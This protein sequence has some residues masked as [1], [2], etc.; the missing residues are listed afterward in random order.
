MLSVQDQAILNKISGRDIDVAMAHNNL[1]S[2]CHLLYPNFYTEE[3]EYLRDLCDKVEHFIEHSDK[4]FLIINAPPRHGKSLTAQCSTAWIFGR[5][6]KHR[7]M[8]ASYN[9]DVASVFSRSVRDTISTEPMGE[10]IVY[11]TIFPKSK[12]KYGDAAA[13]SWKLEGNNQYAYLA[14]SPNGTATGFGC[15]FLICDDLIKNA[16]EAYNDAALEKTWSWFTNTM[17]SRLEGMRKTIVIMTRW[18]TGD[19]AGRIMNSYGDDLEVIT[20]RAQSKEGKMLCPEI[21]DAKSYDLIK[22][23]MNPDIAEANYNQTPI[24]IKGRLYEELKVWKEKPEM[25]I[26]RAM[27]DTA[28]KGDDFYVSVVYGVYEHEAY[29][30][31]V[32]CSDK[33][34]EYTE[35]A[36]VTQFTEY[37]VNKADF[38]S[39]NGGRGI[40]R[41]VERLLRESGNYKTQII[42]HDQ[43]HN[44]ESRILASSSWVQN[45]VYMPLN[46]KNKFPAF[47]DQISK[48]QRKGKNAHDDALDVL[49]SIY[50]FVA[51]KPK[52]QLF[53]ASRKSKSR[54]QPF[55]R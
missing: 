28:D 19:L 49:A 40:A 42:T 48:Y 38:E 29:I 37:E 24:D 47:Y 23:E 33:P 10:R 16:E 9:E 35:P 4:H 43:T 39:N 20:Y 7:V 41:N 18:A 27:V 26:I 1:W 2:F 5:N 8:T 45:H 44:K 52:G 55:T 12:I 36:T 3:R 54:H 46:W 25:P 34:A 22:R 53:G 31:D 17:L 15:E 50:E 14:T 21:L 6:P 13:K 32:I 11:R 30:L 51:N